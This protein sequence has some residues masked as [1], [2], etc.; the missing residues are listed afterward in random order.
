T[1][2]LKILWRQEFMS[3]KQN[4]YEEPQRSYDA[5]VGLAKACNVEMDEEEIMAIFE[6]G[7]KDEIRL[8]VMGV[9]QTKDS[10]TIVKV[11]QM[12]H[13]VMKRSSFE[14]CNERPIHIR[15]DFRCQWE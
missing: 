11:A 5:L 2:E 15:Q 7:L 3:R 1:P 4:D 10:E 9:V 12:K 13:D 8:H 6:R 14:E